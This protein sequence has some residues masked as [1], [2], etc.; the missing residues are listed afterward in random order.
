M[1][2]SVGKMKKKFVILIII[3]VNHQPSTPTNT[4]SIIIINIIIDIITKKPKTPITFLRKKILYT[5]VCY[6]NSLA[7]KIIMMLRTTKRSP[8]KKQQQLRE[9]ERQFKRIIC[10]K[11]GNYDKEPGPGPGLHGVWFFFTWQMKIIIV[12]LWAK[13]K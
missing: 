11:N 3:I 6:F 13:E 4:T 7:C 5:G 8:A 12:S 1:F 9:S 2:F 10:D